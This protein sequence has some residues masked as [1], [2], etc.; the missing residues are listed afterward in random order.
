MF[1]QFLTDYVQPDTDGVN[2]VTYGRVTDK[3][4]AILDQYIRDLGATRV[5]TQLSGATGFLDQSLQCPD[6]FYSSGALSG[7][8]HS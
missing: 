6:H 7:Q 1:G 3:D 2:R 8:E 4:R 5:E